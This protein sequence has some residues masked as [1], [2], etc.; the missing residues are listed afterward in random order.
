MENIKERLNI[1]EQALFTQADICTSRGSVNEFP[2]IL[3]QPF[4]TFGVG[5]IVCN[6]GSFKFSLS[7][8]E[9]SAKAGE[10]VLLPDDVTL[11]VL[12]HSSD[13]DINI[14]IY[15]VENIRDILGNL[16]QPIQLYIKMSPNAYYVWQTNE[17]DDLVRYMHLLEHTMAGQKDN[18]FLL[19][20]Q[21]LL[22]L[23][24][25]YRLCYIFQQKFLSSEPTSMRKTKVFLKLIEL[26]DKYYM[27]QRGVEFYA[28]KLYLSP[29]Y[30]SGLSKSVCGYTVQELVFKAIIRKSLSLLNG[31]TYTIQEIAVMF[32]FPNPSSFGTFFKK[33]MGVSPQKY[34]ESQR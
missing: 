29:K 22:L 19:Y 33:Q 34:R 15:R 11:Q 12:S 26:I 31:T 14:L 17:G 5:L 24:L 28:D 10:V 21:K 27:E 23:S 20:E 25:T 8:E 32:N 9:Y 18:L 30:L 13:L 7:S 4:R 16:V 6:K 1:L 3:K 2:P